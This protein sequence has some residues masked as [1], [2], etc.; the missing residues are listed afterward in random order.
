[1]SGDRLV[2]GTHPMTPALARIPRPPATALSF[3]SPP[4]DS[5]LRPSSAPFTTKSPF[6]PVKR[7]K[8]ALIQ[9]PVVGHM[10]PFLE[11]PDVSR[12]ML[13]DDELHQ[14]VF[15]ADCPRI[16]HV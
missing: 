12:V 4:F 5:T 13:E 2:S 1:M 8:S 16:H 11:R 9:R 7:P 6:N 10:S 15:S 14:Q 3:G